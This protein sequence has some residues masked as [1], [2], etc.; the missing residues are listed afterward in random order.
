MAE[1][2]DPAACRTCGYW[3]ADIRINRCGCHIHS[4]CLPRNFVINGITKEN[5]DGQGCPCCNTAVTGLYLKP[6]SFHDL[7]DSVRLRKADVL[8]KSKSKVYNDDDAD[9]EARYLV[10]SQGRNTVSS[11][12]SDTDNARTGR[13][14]EGEVAFVDHLVQAFDKGVLPLPQGVKLSTFLGDVLLC[15]A[16][17]LTKKMKNARLSTRSFEVKQTQVSVPTKEDYEVFGA[18]QD[19]F[20]S[21]MPTKVAQLEL[22]FNLIKQWRAYFSNLCIETGFKGLDAND[23]I[24][25][26]DEFECMA[27]KTEE[28]MRIV[29]RKRMGL[30][31]CS[32][33]QHRPLKQARSEP[34]LQEIA[35]KPMPTS[36]SMS[37]FGMEL[38]VKSSSPGPPIHQRAHCEDLDSAI[39]SLYDQDENNFSSP[40][41]EDDVALPVPQALPS[42]DDPFLAEISRFMEDRKLPFQHADVW[43]PSFAHGSGEEVQLLHAGHATRRDQGGIL[44]DTLKTFGE[45]SKTFTFRPNQGLPGRAYTT[46]KAQWDSHLSNPAFFARSKGAE[47]YGLRTAIGIP[48]STPGVGRIVVV[49][50]SS[51]KLEEDESLVSR[52]TSELVSYVPTPKWKLVIEMGNPR[53]KELNQEGHPAITEVCTGTSEHTGKSVVVDQMIS[54]LGNELASA[55]N[56]DRPPQQ[57][58]SLQMM[59]MRI[60]L[61]KRP[62]NR[63][64]KEKE[65]VEILE[66]SYN[67]YAKDNTRSQSE[68]ARLL[69][70]EYMCLN[71][72]MDPGN[73]EFSGSEPPMEAL[74]VQHQESATMPS[75]VYSSTQLEVPGA[76][77]P[78]LGRRNVRT[79]NV[80]SDANI[81]R[82]VSVSGIGPGGAPVPDPVFNDQAPSF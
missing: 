48:I 13:W 61:L 62:S 78:P 65:L 70:S 33:G 4:R 56:S 49:F 9:V 28:Q 17:R 44:F 16:S 64:E 31:G 19:R 57:D 2:K 35:S 80:R 76:I 11:T 77:L 67:A 15:K 55:S 71:K 6:L 75:R 46:G 63:S 41:D 23:W 26:V 21:S 45:F 81:R 10:F 51:S 54:L 74:H 72:T 32:T 20:I 58:M 7:E 25:S 37:A 24:S 43:V 22:K 42:S 29:R 30:G 18:L 1:M 79:K 47:A 66:G 39:L 53:P 34:M 8:K 5:G 40:F 38:T 60:L 59:G 3:G 36:S 14:T 12:L 27:S 68:L 69:V 82:T 73:S 52:C 50:Y